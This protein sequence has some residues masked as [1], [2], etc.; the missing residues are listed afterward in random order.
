MMGEGRRFTIISLAVLAAACSDQAQMQTMGAA[1]TV[2]AQLEATFPEAFSMVQRVRELPDGRLMVA[3]PL[4]QVLVVADLAAGTADT[5]GAVGRGPEEYNQPDAV[6][7]LP[8]DSTLLVDLGNARLTTVA[9]DGRF[10]ATM[11]MVT[12]DPGAGNLQILIPQ[13]T[14]S[15]GGVYFQPMGGGRPGG[16]F[17]DSSLVAR[18]DRASGALDT[19]AL[20][21]R[22]E[23]KQ[24]TSGTPGNQNISIRPVPLSAEDA[25]AV[26]WDGRV[27]VARSGDYHVE[28]IEPDGQVTRGE[29][30]PYE[31][32]A[33]GRAEQEEWIEGLGNGIRVGISFDDG[34]RRMSMGRGGGEDLP[35]PG[36]FEWPETKPPFVSNGVYV[37][38]EGDMWVERHVPA[39]A[40]VHFDIFGKDA[41]LK[42]SITF[43]A[44]LDLVGFGHG[45][46]YM[47]RTDEM[48]LQR[49]EVYARPAT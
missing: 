43:P 39:G 33:I 16:Q 21:K 36:D 41:Q 14:D 29:P 3:D 40:D 35:E 25:W 26:S 15:R 11:P 48:G 27:A 22:P 5:L 49:L 28:W 9:P 37:T 30:V 2:A 38:P 23:L 32:V 24:T 7:P 4:G 17:P 8:G 19:L 20:V 12:G 45:R 47:V 44:G 46:T 42:G 13:A 34:D 18:Y 10:A 6:F 1:G 31:P